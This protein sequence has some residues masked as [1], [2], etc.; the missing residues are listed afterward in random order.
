MIM[1]RAIARPHSFPRNSNIL[2]R[3]FVSL[4]ADLAFEG[5]SEDVSKQIYKHSKQPQT[6]VSLKTLLQTGR[7]EFLHKT[8]PDIE[9]NEERGATEQVLTQVSWGET[10]AI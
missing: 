2:L 6:S 5:V 10:I 3:S 8:I 1:R 9:E 7:G 4:P